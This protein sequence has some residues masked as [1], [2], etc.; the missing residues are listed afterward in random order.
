MHNYKIDYKKHQI[1]LMFFCCLKQNEREAIEMAPP[2]NRLE[3]FYA[4]VIPRYLR[5]C[6]NESVSLRLLTTF[7]YVST[8]LWQ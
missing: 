4:C 7:L 1:I 5:I 3:Y 8:L 2:L 6:R